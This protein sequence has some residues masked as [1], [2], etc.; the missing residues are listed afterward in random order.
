MIAAYALLPPEVQTRHQLVISCKVLPDE[1][2]VLRDLAAARG[3]TG[4]LLL[5][6]YVSDDVLVRLYQGC[7]LFVFPSLYEGFG[8]PVLEAMRC[9]APVIAGDVSSL[10]ELVRDPE[11]RFDPTSPIT[12]RDRMQRGVEDLEFRSRLRAVAVSESQR[13]T[14]D[15][16]VE[17]TL[18]GYRFAHGER[19]RPSA[20]RRFRLA[21]FSPW[22]PQE[23]G[24]ADY[25]FRLV[26]ELAR[27]CDV[28][29]FVDGEPAAYTAPAG[30]GVRLCNGRDFELLRLIERYDR[31][32]YCMGNSA[33]H[34]YL[35][36][37]LT[38]YRG[39]VLMHDLRLT[40][41]YSWVGQHGRVRRDFLHQKLREMY[42]SRL[43]PELKDPNLISLSPD[44]ARRYGVFMAR[45]VIEKADRVFLHSEAAR[46]I[47][48]LDSGREGSFAA[49]IPFGHPDLDPA[50]IPDGPPVVASFGIV[51]EIKQASLLIR[52]VPELSRLLPEVKLVFAGHMYPD[53][54][55]GFRRLAKELGVDTQVVFTGRI[56]AA[57]YARRLQ[58]AQVAVQLRAVST[59]ESSASVADCLAA[60]L[61]TVVS[62]I[63]ALGELPRDAVVHVPVEVD[64]T[65]LARVIA[66]LLDDRTRS[67]ELRRRAREYAQANSFAQ[68]ADRLSE[69]LSS[70]HQ[71][72]GEEG[73]SELL[74]AA[75]P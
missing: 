6:G 38:R 20:P 65:D 12:L 37:V 50:P 43:P 1:E 49:V 55:E 5:T 19:S 68:A 61:P 32:L 56:S 54:G 46:R 2:R 74:T 48:L 52:A 44:Q 10:R 16:V 41:F 26:Q 73:A 25:S 21:F 8:L 14:W 62:D 70:A 67:H 24:V 33:V 28:D 11:A 36:W 64:P 15:K 72:T 30:P 4:E 22:P 40:G 58:S 59:G 13:F 31:L 3:L 51:D 29:V 17:E 18:R 23:S 7:G 53:Q 57:E 71:G 39:D 63:G 60:G 45:E 35:W 9:G 27:H 34:E 69:H 75:R 42:G 47:A 66:G